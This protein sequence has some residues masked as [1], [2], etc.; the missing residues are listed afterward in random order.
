MT[1]P[2]C[3]TWQP[4]IFLLAFLLSTGLPAWSAEGAASGPID[5]GADEAYR[6][7][8]GLHNVPLYREAET[9]LRA[10]LNAYP[11][12]PRTDRVL[13]RLGDCLIH[14]DRP[15][16]AAE[17]FRHMVARFP[18]SERYPEAL[19]RL[20]ELEHQLG[21]PP[22]AQRIFERF[23][24][25]F[26]QHALAPAAREK[27]QVAAVAA[28]YA[29]AD[30]NPEKALAMAN[31][32][33]NRADVV[34][35]EALFLRGV[36]LF[37]G[38][39]LLDAARSFEALLARFPRSNRADEAHFNAGQ[40]YLRRQEWPHACRHLGDVRAT[41]LDEARYWKGVALRQM[42]QTNDAFA[43]FQEVVR[44]HRQ[45]EFR[46]FALLELGAFGPRDAWTT[47]QREY[48]A[49]EAADESR[50]RMAAAYVTAGQTNEAVRVLEGV[51]ANSQR[52]VEAD[53]LRVEALAG[54]KWPDA[55][56]LLTTLENQGIPRFRLTRPR[57]AVGIAALDA[58]RPD[59]AI[60]LLSQVL[61]DPDAKELHPDC[62][63][64]MGL[65]WEQKGDAANAIA[66]FQR[67]LAAAPM[68][69]LAPFAMIR[70]AALQRERAPADAL[71]TLQRLLADHPRFAHRDQAEA[72]IAEIRYREGWAA[73]RTNHYAQAVA[74]F[75][76]LRDHPRYGA[77]AAHLAG[78]SC[79]QMGQFE[80]AERHWASLLEQWPAYPLASEVRERL[81]TL[82]IERK[83]WADA[84]AQ[85]GILAEAAT[86]SLER[87]R[88]L[89]QQGMALYQFN[90]P[91]RARE[92][93]L[94]A[95]E[96]G[97]PAE[98]AKALFFLGEL[99]LLQ[100]KPAEAKE[101]F[102]KSALLVRHEE[103]TPAALLQ[104][105]RSL[106]ALN[107]REQARAIFLRLKKEYPR[108]PQAVEAD[109]LLP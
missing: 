64:R 23:I 86:N 65:A 21:N 106:L 26:P 8:V 38:G 70:L 103:L 109:R 51:P 73:F 100:K 97:A 19:F 85:F 107:D 68:D 36:L 29:Q 108:S 25:E 13:Y 44:E 98:K 88:A 96:H 62:H 75:E 18:K 58:Q 60:G 104:A 24:R 59:V 9:Q 17:T 39:Q 76:P 71:Q 79:Q 53:L 84:V 34:G 28:L 27:E 69:S 81:A 56:A 72:L 22:E 15:Q 66:A 1:L 101:Y 31:A 74:W 43:A 4:P 20:A 6:L 57:Y 16:E 83:K 95:A 63:Y 82:L 42:G 54:W 11:R 40:A 77:E 92:C 89:L 78:L 48:P 7:A 5:S 93:L 52:R 94:A 33:T 80:A 105:G 2:R 10:F 91:V 46:P 49:H 67:V 90:Q 47:L 87:A 35:E 99:A 50:F 3:W 12:D 37:N 102:L 30:R 55:A 14:L 61:E 41:R 45:S 32:F